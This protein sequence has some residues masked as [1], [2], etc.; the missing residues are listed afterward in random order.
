MKKRVALIG[1]LAIAYVLL[2][3]MGLALA[4][5]NPSASVVWPNSGLALAALLTGG[6]R[7]WPGIFLGAFLVNVT[8]T[9]LVFPSVGIAVGN[10]LEA[11]MGA[12]LTFR[13]AGGKEA[14]FHTRRILV[15]LT[16][17]GLLSTMIS[18]TIGVV[19]LVGAG[20]ETLDR[21]WRVWLTWW[22]GDAN[23]V[24]VVAPIILLCI[25][26]RGRPWTWSRFRPEA[27][28]LLLAVI[29]AGQIMFNGVLTPNYALT[30]L[31][32][33]FFAWA[34]FRFGQREAAVT[35]LVFAASAVWGTF[36]A[37]AGA[38]RN[39]M[40]E[41]L[42]I[43]QAFLG[44]AAVTNIVLATE[45]SERRRAEAEARSLAT[46]DPL[47]G[48]GNHRKFIDELGTEIQRA[49]RTGRS[50]AILLIDLDGLKRINDTLGHL[51]GNRA[52]CR[53]A[54]VLRISCRGGDVAVRY[55]G[56][57]FAAILLESDDETA[58]G[59]ARRIERRLR[60]SD[61]SPALSA[62]IGAAVWP[63]DGR[64]I[65][66]LL[67]TADSGLYAMKS[68]RGKRGASVNTLESSLRAHPRA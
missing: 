47:T 55:G 13:F 36:N 61:E 11:V 53:V 31:C 14:I 44:V 48:L 26:H 34:A 25:A 23:G 16:L 51:A 18:A 9:G 43:L 50:F 24:I 22:M 42:L 54:D 38:G 59:V 35:M 49:E 52:L 10:T 7:L 60:A 40:D 62:S 28:L 5:V 12:W 57:E 33:P 20:Q 3:K 32:M 66:V 39:P 4:V 21:F 30:Y 63:H 8:T 58:H 1:L 37:V 67:Q 64:S 15:F 6:F 45:V 27:V 19:S 29:L 2:G 68:A 41:S 56:D 17:A 65:D 46:I